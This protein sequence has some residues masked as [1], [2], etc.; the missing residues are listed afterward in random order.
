M[1][2]FEKISERLNVVKK[3]NVF[4][5]IALLLCMVGIVSLVLLQLLWHSF[6]L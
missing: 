5:I 3:F 4:G 6:F 1:E 2:M